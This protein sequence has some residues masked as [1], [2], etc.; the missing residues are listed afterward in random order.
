MAHPNEELDRRGFD[1]FS[2]GDVDALRALFDQTPS[3]MRRAGG[4]CRVTTAAWTRSSAT[5]LDNGATAGT[6][7]VEFH[8][9][10]ANDEHTVAMYVARG[11]REGE[12]LEDQSML[13]SH[14]RSGKFTET[15]QYF[16]DQY[17]GDEFLA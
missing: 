16:E 17:A 7:R 3:G 8:D 5:S 9:A 6:F 15:W 11:E 13:I 1:A 14:V 2:K 10:L 4:P 12:T